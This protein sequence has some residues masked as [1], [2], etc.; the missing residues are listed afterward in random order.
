MDALNHL[1]RRGRYLADSR[2]LHWYKGTV[3]DE[4]D[5]LAWI[6][7]PETVKAAS[8]ATRARELLTAIHAGV[9]P[10]LGDSL[11]YACTLSGM[12]GR[13][14]VRDW[15]EGMFPKLVEAIGAWF[16]ILRSLHATE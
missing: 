11:Y 9:R 1:N 3:P 13:V 2:V 12:S 14:M 10:D 5:P 8:A 7:E 6:P 16:G 4:D 15:M